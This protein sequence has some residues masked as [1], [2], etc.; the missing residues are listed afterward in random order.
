MKYE[1]EISIKSRSM[2]KIYISGKN[3]DTN[4]YNYFHIIFN[5]QKIRR[6]WKYIFMYPFYFSLKVWTTLQLFIDWHIVFDH[7]V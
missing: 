1:V 4:G 2:F 3:L 5:I 6:T 7:N